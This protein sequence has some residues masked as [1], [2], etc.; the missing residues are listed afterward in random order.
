MKKAWIVYNIGNSMADYIGNSA[1]LGDEVN[2]D[3]S[4]FERTDS[5]TTP[6]FSVRRVAARE[7]ARKNGGGGL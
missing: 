1:A 6:A 5:K 2:D 7:K 4:Y 3:A